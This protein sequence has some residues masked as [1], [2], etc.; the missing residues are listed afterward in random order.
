MEDNIEELVGWVN[1]KME[2]IEM[3]KEERKRLG[4]DKD[5]KGRFNENNN[6]RSK[7]YSRG[8]NS[9]A[10]STYSDSR[11]SEKEIRSIKKWVVDK[12]RGNRKCNIVIKGIN[13]S[14]ENIDK[15]W[16]ERFTEKR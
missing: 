1:K 12:D 13:I 8:N 11:L 5:E 14:E 6:G 2:E 16:V 9:Y 3:S 4:E 15:G 7:S 10:G